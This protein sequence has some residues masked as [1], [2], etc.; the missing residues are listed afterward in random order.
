MSDD[1]KQDNAVSPEERRFAGLVLRLLG[2][3]PIRV[4]RTSSPDA[5]FADLPDG[6]RVVAKT[7]GWLN[8]PGSPSVEAWVYA[9]CARRGIR[10]ASVLAVSAD[11]ECLVLQRLPGESLPRRS[12][13]LPA[14]EQAVWARAGEDLRALHEVRLVGFGTLSP[15]GDGSKPAGKADRWCPFAEFAR[16]EGI[17]W[18]VDGG[19]LPTAQG[20]RLL[21]RIEEA[22]AA[23]DEVTEGRLL[24]GDLMSTHIFRSPDGAYEGLIDFGQAQSGDPRW[25]LAR[26]PLW[27]GAE[28]LDAV[29]DGYGSDVVTK[30]DREFLLPLYLLSFVVRHAVGHDRPDYIRTLLDRSGY[31]VLL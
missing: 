25:D 12:S 30:E 27:D 5:W 31:R 23:F 11:P 14:G 17:R 4:D 15:R 3:E 16:T 7:P 29:L 1:R 21:A 24:H 22:Q 9:E 2:I 28:A 20:D 26:V 6:R 19:Y 18:L 13:S 8:S 10:T